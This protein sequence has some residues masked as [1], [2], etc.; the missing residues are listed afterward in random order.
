[1]TMTTYL[2]KRKIYIRDKKDSSERTFDEYMVYKWSDH[3]DNPLSM[4]WAA[5]KPYD[6]SKIEKSFVEAC[7]L[8]A[9]LNTEADGKIHKRQGRYFTYRTV[10]YMVP[11]T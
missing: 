3:D 4:N 2:I 1:M 6:V 9:K 11:N 10:F 8:V 5:E 7:K